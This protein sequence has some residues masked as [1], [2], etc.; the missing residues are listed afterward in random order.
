MS[1]LT[2]AATVFVVKH[3]A[4]VQAHT[5]YF[6]NMAGGRARELN[7]GMPT[8]ESG[9]RLAADIERRQTELGDTTD[10]SLNAGIVESR[11]EIVGEV[12]RATS[13][14]VLRDEAIYAKLA[15][16]NEQRAAAKLVDKLASLNALGGEPLF[17]MGSHT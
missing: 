1:P 5:R 2:A 11:A 10:R 4:S 8:R 9:K 17:H 3:D 15:Y 16:R 6:K 7:V 13:D 14:E 12:R